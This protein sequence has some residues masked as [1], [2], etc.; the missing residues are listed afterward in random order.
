MG[1]AHCCFAASLE[2][3]NEQTDVAIERGKGGRES[4][5]L[6]ARRAAAPRGC[7]GFLCEREILICMTAAAVGMTKGGIHTHAR[8]TYR[9]A[10][11]YKNGL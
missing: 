11:G 8:M 9:V 5:Q 10:N 7:S 1:T 6:V 4:E 2:R 3:T